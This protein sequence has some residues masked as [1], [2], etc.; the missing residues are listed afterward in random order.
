MLVEVKFLSNTNHLEERT[1]LFIC[2]SLE[3]LIEFLND[4]KINWVDITTK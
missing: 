3:D 1:R 2:D 4:A